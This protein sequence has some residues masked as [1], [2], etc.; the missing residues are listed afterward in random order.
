MSL[1]RDT[2]SVFNLPVLWCRER[3]ETY[4]LSFWP[5]ILSIS[6]YSGAGSGLKLMV[7]WG[8]FE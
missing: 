1:S 4:I 7:F 8:K 3:I 6:L 2:L 5:Y